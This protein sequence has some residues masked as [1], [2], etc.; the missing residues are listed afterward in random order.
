MEPERWREIEGIYHQALEQESSRRTVWLKQASHGDESLEQEVRSLLEESDD[1]GAFLEEPALEVAGRDLARFSVSP[2]HP[3]MIGRYR[4]VRLLG[5]GGMGAVYEAEQEGPRRVVAL[6]VIRPGLATPE[7]L[8]RFRHESQAL[9]RLQH[10]GIAQ[11]YEAGTGN[12]GFGTQPYF[13]MELVRGLSLER[14]AEAHALNSRQRLALVTEVCSAVEHAHQRGLIHR[15]LKPGNILVDETGQPKILDFGVARVI[16]SNAEQTLETRFGDLVG[17]LAYM[18]PEQVTGDPLEV[19]TRS[20]V[21]SLGVILYELLTG[22]LPY[23]VKGAH[24]VQ[25]AQTIREQDPPSLSSINDHFRGDI[26]TI[27]GKALEKDKARRYASAADLGADIQRYLDDQ[28]VTARPASASY[29]LQKFARRHRAL[30]FAASAV[31]LALMAGVAASTLEAVR[32][33]REGQLAIR[34]RDLAAGAERNARQESDHALPAE[35]AATNDRNRAIAAEAKALEQRNLALAEKR[36][37]DEE[38]ATAKAVADFLQ[39]DLLAQAGASTQAGPSRKPDPDLK[40]RTALDRAAAS[41]PGK[42]DK[43]PLVEASIRLTIGKAYKDLGIYSEAQVQLE[44]ALDLRRRVLGENHPD[45]LMSITDLFGLYWAEGKYA[46]AEPFMT[47]SLAIEQRILGP[48]HPDT[49]FTLNS[50]AALKQAEGK[51]PQAENFYAQA[52]AIE[53]SALGQENAHTLTTMN[54]IASLYDREGKYPEAEELFSKVLEIKRRTLGEEHPSTLRSMNNLAGTY[55][56]EHKFAQAEP[57][58]AKALEI[59]RRVLGEEHP[60][61]LTAMNNLAAL[62]RTQGMYEQANDLQS[63]AIQVEIRVLGEEHPRTLTSMKNLAAGYHGEGKYADAEQLFKRILE[64]ERRVF[65]EEH[66][67]TLLTIHHLI[68]VY[69]DEGEYADAEPLLTKALEIERRTPGETHPTMTRDIA[70][71]GEVRLRQRKYAL[72][73]PPLREALDKWNSAQPDAW[74]RHWIQALLGASLAGQKQDRE[75]EMLL[76]AGCEGLLSRESAI[77]GANRRVFQAAREWIVQFYESASKPEKAA[78]WRQ[79]LAL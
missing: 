42:F 27:V 78:E 8:W 53:R 41:I 62:Y 56:S 47:R 24:L 58:N 36:R 16:E 72:A 34:E 12:T 26:E 18:S 35:R 10:P 71:L 28:P 38:S 74:Q 39:K 57:L 68:S 66:P 63:Q 77:T 64:I 2:S 49:A 45:M 44:R 76:V 11:I 50:L 29:Q 33:N 48:K 40:V 23:D 14:Y 13:A 17:T 65:G 69:R 43:Q 70:A 52:L 3:A 30:V 6:K 4:I 55:Q 37:A 59:E 46:Q 20:D 25:A 5:E 67:D 19:D 32:A 9:G 75:A 54:N 51:F 73:E 61:T 31:F 7:R 60:S 22:R 79:R 15:D 1:E 21:Y